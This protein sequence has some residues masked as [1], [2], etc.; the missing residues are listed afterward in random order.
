MTYLITGVTGHLGK[1]ILDNLVLQTPKEDIAVLV[2]SEEKGQPF[3]KDGF[4]VRIGDYTDKESLE[5][6]FQGITTLMFVSGEPG[7][8]TPR[9]VQHQNVIAAATKARIKKIVYTSIP[10]GENSDSILAP[11]H[12]LTEKLIKESGITYKILRN[13]WYLE[14]ESGI[15]QTALAGKGFVYAAGEGQVG[16]VLRRDLA[17][18]AANALVQPFDENHILELSGKAITYQNLYQAFKE[19]TEKDVEEVSLS[20]DDYKKGLLAAGVPQD[21][22]DFATA[23]QNDI[24]NGALEVTRTDLETLLGRPQT[25]IAEAIEE[26]LN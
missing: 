4:D 22:A 8:E 24:A 11:D 25:P 16:W 5:K 21:E 2:R 12:I 1:G 19:A 3:A 18:A 6:A 7:Q 17:E 15:F 10:K 9:N 20:L 13:N 14:N 26:L 23:I